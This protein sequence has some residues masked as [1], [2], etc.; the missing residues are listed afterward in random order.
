MMLIQATWLSLLLSLIPLAR[1]P[2]AQPD[3]ERNDSTP[4]QEDERLLPDGTYC[5][6]EIPLPSIRCG[7]TREEVEARCAAS[8]GQLTGFVAFDPY[9][10]I[11]HYAIND[12]CIAVTYDEAMRVRSFR[13]KDRRQLIFKPCAGFEDKKPCEPP[14]CTDASPSVQ[15]TDEDAAAVGNSGKPLQW[16]WSKEKASLAYSTKH[17]LPDYDVER[18]REK[19]Y[20]TPIKIRTKTDRKVIYILEDGHE[21]TVFT[22]WKDVLYIAEYSPIGT[23]CEVVALDLMTGTQLWKSR[24]EGIGPTGHSQ[25]SNLVNIE[26]D[27][28]RVIVTGNETHGR[29]V[30]HLD[31]ASGK[32]LTNK[33]LDAD[34]Q[35]FYGG[36]DRENK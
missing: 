16:R 11:E 31:L 18:V 10:Y 22:R 25:Y 7:M 15:P 36:N 3:P 17:H 23:G 6:G 27:G 34:P 28:W 19:G 1:I 13:A 32:T 12:F 14:P 2:T 21:S 20:Y 33:K 24:L 5:T 29:Y 26:T 35:S 4:S 30:E 8:G 9:L